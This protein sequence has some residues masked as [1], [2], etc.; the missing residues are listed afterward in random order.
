MKCF[1]FYLFLNRRCVFFSCIDTNVPA[2]WLPPL[3]RRTRARG[4]SPQTSPQSPSLNAHTTSR[5]TR[6][7]SVS[8]RRLS[9]S[10]YGGCAL[11]DTPNT[12][13]ARN[14]MLSSPYWLR[15]G[16]ANQ[17]RNRERRWCLGCTGSATP[18]QGCREEIA[19]PK[20]CPSS[21]LVPITTS[22][23]LAYFFAIRNFW[24]SISGC[25]SVKSDDCASSR[26]AT[27]LPRS[28]VGQQP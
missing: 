13:L 3:S 11:H 27:F 26:V 18:A 20:C 16:A 19:H 23:S 2:A 21:E 14:V 24:G 22:A 5:S 10:R 15:K 1:Y 17:N 9:G 7:Q 8:P 25:L 28:G 6:V 4:R 12:P